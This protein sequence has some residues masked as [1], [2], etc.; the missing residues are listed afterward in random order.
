[1]SGRVL[2]NWFLDG[3]LLYHVKEQQTR[4]FLTIADDIFLQIGDRVGCGVK[5]DAIAKNSGLA[6]SMVPVFFTKN[7]KEIG[8][9]L[10]PSPPGGLYPAIG[11][12]REPEEVGQ[13]S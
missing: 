1:M 5:F 3:K 6:A 13:Q 8:T 11:L 9:Q 4:S 10:I 7:G 12:Q 2:S